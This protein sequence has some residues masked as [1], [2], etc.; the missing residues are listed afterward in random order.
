MPIHTKCCRHSVGEER[1]G[2][3]GYNDDHEDLP[4][5]E[6]EVG[7]LVQHHG[8]RRV[9]RQQGEAL[10]RPGTEVVTI[11]CRHDVGVPARQLSISKLQHY[12]STQTC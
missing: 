12:L 5:E 10:P 3:G 1:E 7:D 2:G 9:L 11:D 6:H 8:P 4:H